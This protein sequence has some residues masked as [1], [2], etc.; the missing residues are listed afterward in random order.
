[1]IKGRVDK[2]TRVIP[3]RALDTNGLV[4]CADLLQGLGNNRDVVLAKQRTVETIIRPDNILHATDSKLGQ[5]LLLLD[6]E[7][8]DGGGG[9][10]EQAASAA[11]VDV[12]GTGWGLDGLCCGVAKILDVDLLAGGV[13]D[14]KAIAGNEDCGGGLAALDVGGVDGT[15]GVA[16]KVN[17][18]VGSAVGGRGD[19]NGAL[20]RVVRKSARRNPGR[21][22]LAQRQHGRR[23]D[24]LAEIV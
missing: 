15:R 6:I 19:Q 1:M 21:A 8:G 22:E 16:R 9:N 4:Q 10:E 14:R 18:L 17:Q 12:R 20:G 2:H 3:S 11:E 13:E 23:L 24:V 5:L 7:E